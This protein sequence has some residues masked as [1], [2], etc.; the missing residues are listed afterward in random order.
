MLNE[1]KWKYF[2]SDCAR[3]VIEEELDFKIN[4]EKDIATATAQVLA[5]SKKLYESL[6][7]E[8]V[9]LQQV[10]KILIEKKKASENFLNKTGLVWPF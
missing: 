9:D 4:G 1:T 5:C 2:F 8:D 7:S 10:K 6:C 3:F